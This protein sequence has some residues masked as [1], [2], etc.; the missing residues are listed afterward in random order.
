MYVT[1]IKRKKKKYNFG[2]TSSPLSLV[3]LTGEGNYMSQENNSIMLIVSKHNHRSWGC[4]KNSFINIILLQNSFVH[5]YTDMVETKK[6][7]FLNTYFSRVLE[8]WDQW[9][10]SAIKFYTNSCYKKFFFR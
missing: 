10:P 1:H 3:L 8:S 9:N 7:I 6:L 4:F 2:D 5:S